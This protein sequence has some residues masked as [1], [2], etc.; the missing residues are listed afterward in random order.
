MHHDFS[1]EKL[2]PAASK[3]SVLQ[4][5]PYHTEKSVVQ[6]SARIE[7]DIVSRHRRVVHGRLR[8]IVWKAS[9]VYAGK[10]RHAVIGLIG[11]SLYVLFCDGK[12][13][14]SKQ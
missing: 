6:V 10:A 5:Q 1:V 7:N 4:M 3:Q 9:A 14:R 13:I 12:I 8:C 11:D 2:G